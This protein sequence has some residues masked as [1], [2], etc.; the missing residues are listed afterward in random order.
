MSFRPFSVTFSVSFWPFL[1]FFIGSF[2][3]K[4]TSLLTC[5]CQRMVQCSTSYIH[6]TSVDMPIACQHWCNQV[7]TTLDQ[8]WNAIMGIGVLK[9]LVLHWTLV[10]KAAL[11]MLACHI[12]TRLDQRWHDN[13]VNIEIPIQIQ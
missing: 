12:G 10:G 1:V 6:W 5:Q 4:K 13:V 8:R 9:T 2:R 11:A 3:S 7:G